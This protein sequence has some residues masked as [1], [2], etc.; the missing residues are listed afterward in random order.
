V[1]TKA[2]ECAL[3]DTSVLINFLA[4]DQATLLL[5]H[6]RYRFILTEHVRYEV[7][8]FYPEQYA[9]LEAVLMEG[10]I[11]QIRVDDPEELEMFAALT[12]LDRFGVGEC[13]AIAAAAHRGCAI[14]IDDRAASNHVR[15]AF[16]A[17][18]L[19]TTQSLVAG[20]IR[21]AVLTVTVADGFKDRWERQH[22]FRLPFASFKDIL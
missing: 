19:E 14:A 16:P 10:A 2:R 17:V 11:E 4:I 22:R 21:A 1:S 7:T 8:E 20:L 3:I 5:L 13:A 6:P 18:S 9:R 15:R 12:I